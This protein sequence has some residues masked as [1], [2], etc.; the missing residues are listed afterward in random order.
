M[1]WVMLSPIDVICCD[2]GNDSFLRWFGRMNLFKALYQI[3]CVGLMGLSSNSTACL[4]SWSAGLSAG[5]PSQTMPA[6]ALLK[7]RNLA[8][9]RL[10]P[11]LPP[12]F[13][14]FVLS[15]L[16]S[17]RLR[18]MQLHRIIPFP[19]R[20]AVRFSLQRGELDKKCASDTW[21]L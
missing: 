2:K 4:L 18:A 16:C 13:A 12:L 20:Q 7:H 11:V 14:F 1:S 19:L 9:A 3:G 5:A 21:D 8:Q 15:G 10:S 6:I 17:A